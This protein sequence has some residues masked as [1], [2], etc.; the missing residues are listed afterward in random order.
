MCVLLLF[1]CTGTSTDFVI[2]CEGEEFPVHRMI[3]EAR[4]PVFRGMLECSMTESKAGRCV[5]KDVIKPVL[6][7]LLQ[8]IYTGMPSFAVQRTSCLYYYNMLL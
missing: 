4:S 3:L 1:A 5:V 2:E 6:Q 7:V 8:F